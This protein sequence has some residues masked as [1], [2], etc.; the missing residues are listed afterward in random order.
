MG[1]LYILPKH[2]S[3]LS[4]GLIVIETIPEHADV[5]H[6]VTSVRPIHAWIYSVGV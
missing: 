4:L 2:G 3:A 6:F 5:I 1:R